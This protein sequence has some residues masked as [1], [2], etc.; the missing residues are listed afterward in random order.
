MLDSDMV[1]LLDHGKNHRLR[2]G[3][4]GGGNSCYLPSF[5]FGYAAGLIAEYDTPAR[6]LENESSL[7]AKLVAE[8]SMRSNSSFENVSDT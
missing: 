4:S 5:F 7:F 8:Y 3:A 2:S 1:L 6:L